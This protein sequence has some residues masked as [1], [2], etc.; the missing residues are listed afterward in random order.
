MSRALLRSCNAAACAA[1]V[2]DAP[3]VL[4]ALQTAGFMLSC[5]TKEPCAKVF[6]NVLGTVAKVRKYLTVVRQA[7]SSTSL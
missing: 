7:P 6:A 1:C 3:A 2:G 4:L 5:I